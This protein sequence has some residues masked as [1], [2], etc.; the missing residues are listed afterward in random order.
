[1]NQYIAFQKH[2]KF[3]HYHLTSFFNLIKN[4]IITNLLLLIYFY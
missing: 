4:F 1:M 2:N 3:L